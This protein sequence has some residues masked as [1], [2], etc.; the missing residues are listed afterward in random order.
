MSEPKESLPSRLERFK[1]TFPEHEKRIKV[2]RRMVSRLPD[3]ERDAE[4]HRTR[5]RP[6]SFAEM[7]RV[8][9]NREQNGD[10]EVER[11]MRE[12]E[13]SLN[14]WIS[15]LDEEYS[16]K[17]Y[18]FLIHQII[19]PQILGVRDSIGDQPFERRTPETYAPYPRLNRE[20]LARVMDKLVKISEGRE[21]G[22]M[23]FIR[24][25]EKELHHVEKIAREQVARRFEGI[26]HEWKIYRG[27][28]GARE[29]EKDLRDK[30][31][32]WCIAGYESAYGTYLAHRDSLMH[33]C[34]R[35]D[36]NA[37]AA[38]YV[39]EGNIREIRGSAPG[40]HMDGDA[41]KR[42]KDYIRA[43]LSAGNDLTDLDQKFDDV[44]TLTDIIDGGLESAERS[45]D[46]ARQSA[47][48]SFLYEIERPIKGFGYGR[49]TRIDAYRKGH[50][51]MKDA[52][53]IFQN[54]ATAPAAIT[55][56]TDA[57]IGPISSDLWAKLGD[58]KHIYT[59]FP[60]GKIICRDITLK[61]TTAED[62]R[63]NLNAA[64]VSFGTHAS[65]MLNKI[66]KQELEHAE[67]FPTYTLRVCDL[68]TSEELK[69]FGTRLPTTKDIFGERGFDGKFDFKRIHALG[70]DICPSTVALNI[71]TE[72]SETL[73]S[74]Q[75]EFIAMNAIP[76]RDSDP[77]V[78]RV[79]RFDD[80]SLELY[81][82]WANPGLEWDLDNGLVFRPRK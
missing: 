66:P 68:F 55:P 30:G 5:Y 32:G 10:T 27:Q 8:L 23:D 56:E 11:R 15:C 48:L 52:N 36:N 34:F 33:V 4:G 7:R 2:L 69:K 59:A 45:K 24:E 78:F 28:K 9:R 46:A 64:R 57:Y 79:E 71:L 31:T 50:D 61:A 75:W 26:P 14:E 16:D 70:L 1:K 40:Q 76:D 21:A 73:H 53:V 6:L 12:Q 29:L 47:L 19:A 44:L 39:A 72:H 41:A 18:T 17:K 74:G 20:A 65:D 22:K 60:E 54:L 42:A 51:A 25:Y 62:I 35:G 67:S 82:Y 3:S 63:S 77:H 81:D 37:G 38:L 49:D 13:A 58:I 43:N 80:G